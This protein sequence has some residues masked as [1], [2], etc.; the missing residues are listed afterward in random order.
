[1]P[2]TIL[3]PIALAV[4]LLFS[5][6]GVVHAQTPPPAPV[7]PVPAAEP[8]KAEEK[9]SDEK[10]QSVE[11]IEVTGKNSAE[12]AR[13]NSTAAKIIITREDIARYG[14][15]NIGEVM[16]RL[17]GVTQQG[18]RPGRPGAPAM[19]GMGGGFTQI[20]IDGQRM[21][22]GMSLDQISPEQVE[23]IEILRAPTAETGARAIAGTINIV[24][25]EPIRKT[26]HDVKL[27]ATSERGLWSPNLNYTYNGTAGELVTYNISANGGRTHQLTDTDTL[28]RETNTNT[29]VLIGER[30]SQGQSEE[31]RDN[32][33]VNGRIQWRLGPGEQF[34]IQAFKGRIEPSTQST[35]T[36]TQTAGA[37][38]A[39]Y[40]TRTGSFEGR[41][42][43]SRVNLNLNKKF[44]EQTR[45][46]LRGGVGHFEGAGFSSS[47]QFDAAGKLIT[48][49]TTKTDS[50]DNSWSLNGKVT[51]TFG[52]GK[53][54]VALG[55]EIEDQKRDQNS[56]TLLNGAQQLADLGEEFSVKVRRTA[57]FIQDE[58]EPSENWSANV[59]LRYEAIQTTS[60]TG[61]RAVDNTSRVLSPLGHL[62][63]RFASPRRDQVRL[64]LTQSYRSPNVDQL[65]AR[66][67]LNN[68]YPV[69]G[70]NT[71]VTPDRAGNGLLKPERAN[72]IDLAYEHY[73]KAGG[74]FSVNLFH[75]EIKDLIRNVT[76][77]ETVSW[78]TS[79]RFVNRP[80]NF[81]S[82]TTTGIEFDAKFVLSEF[83]EGAPGINVRVNG[84]LFDSKV[85][86]VPGPNNRIDQQPK[87]TANFG[88]DYKL[89]FAPV[90]V[91]GNISW[92]P[93]Y[94]LRSTVADYQT[95]GL[96]R[97]SEVFA[98]WT[99]SPT[100]KVRVSS[101]NLTPRDVVT[102]N[103]NVSPLVT[104]DSTSFGRTDRSYTIRLE[105]RF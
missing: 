100:T 23:R 47:N 40:A 91:G 67:N 105:M 12:D 69:P 63:W 41:F 7:E 68:T 72:G 8:P 18:G 48:L 60:A 37:L 98:L 59:G 70:P 86:D 77:L 28:T 94:D 25:R 71:V 21:Q 84:A 54:T 38:P 17:P 82:A 92:T 57:A 102:Q 27:G 29:G 85:K 15:S 31:T 51:R 34:G 101:A 24:L 99:I 19:R 87:G 73:L 32:I 96:K 44:D 56:I 13:R 26:D 75:R 93:G 52:E 79:P 89:T 61:E 64:S 35:G 5:A 43:P 14:D 36:L 22:P 20:L 2:R 65:V 16:R 104:T 33:F 80:Q 97:V 53:H 10:A 90:M 62:V 58:W 49:Q 88:G 39:P 74:I 9:K 42:E 78:A 30:F 45:Y 11:K 4:S 81:S 103:I 46:E 3:S 83:V 95:V 55:G 76:S 6:A 1:M 50:K 66:P